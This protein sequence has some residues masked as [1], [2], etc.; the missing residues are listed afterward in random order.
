VRGTDR[1]PAPTR[2][3]RPAYNPLRLPREVLSPIRRSTTRTKRTR[4]EFLADVGRGALLVTLGPSIVSEWGLRG[5]AAGEATERLTFGSLEPLVTLMQET[6]ADALLPLLVG[7]IRAGTDLRTITAAAA[8]ANARQFG[9][10]DYTGYHALMAL[11]PAW[12]MS[13]ESP[14][15]HE[16]LPVLKVAYRSTAQIREKGGAAK[17]VLRPVEPSALPEGRD[18]GEILR[19]AV[20]AGESGDAERPFAAIVRTGPRPAFDALLTAVQDHTEVHRVVL[21]CRSWDLLDVTGP[22]HAETLLRQSV[23]YCVGQS[24]RSNPIRQLLPELFAEHGLLDRAPGAVAVD[25][26]WIAQT[27]RAIFEGTPAEAAERAAAALAKGIAPSAVGEAIT[28]AAVEL[29]LRDPGRGG[30]AARPGKEAG[31]VHGDSIGVHGCDS[32]N[33]WRRLALAGSAR[34]TFACLIAG[35]FQVAAD[36]TDRGGDF[37]Q[38]TPHPLADEAK[39]I[40]VDDPAALLRETDAAIRENRQGRACALTARYEALG[41]PPRALLDLLLRYAVSEDGALHAEKYYATAT[42]EFAAT[43]PAF[44]GRHLVALARVTASAYGRRAPADSEARRLLGLPAMPGPA[45]AGG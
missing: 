12:R 40:E 10:H 22:Q 39:A 13:L 9:G 1:R 5:V 27:S 30:D 3:P 24:G 14:V 43:R 19:E 31:T 37:L 29:V 17:E 25:D 4:R 45:A 34:N 23:R 32:A 41:H 35:A 6:D 16:A 21:A 20:R 42:E 36:R 44:R 33:A 26:A 15:G 18:A 8:L 11:A 28:L 38:R 2:P 7:R